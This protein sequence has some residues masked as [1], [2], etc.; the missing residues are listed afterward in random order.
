MAAAYRTTASGRAHS[1]GRYSA[2]I[3]GTTATSRIRVSWLARLK[4]TPVSHALSC[5][6]A[7]SNPLSAGVKLAPLWPCLKTTLFLRGA[8]NLGDG[9]PQ[10]D[11][12]DPVRSDAHLALG[13]VQPNEVGHSP[14]NGRDY[15]R[16]PYAHH[17]VDGEVTPE[18]DEHPERLVFELSE[19]FLTVEG[20]EHI[21]GYQ[22]TLLDRGLGGRR[23]YSAIFPVHILH[24]GA[25]PYSPDVVVALHPKG[26]VYLYAGPLVVG[27]PEVVYHLVRAVAR[28]PDHVLRIYLLAAFQLDA[29][30]R[31]L[32]GHGASNHLDAFVEEPGA[33]GSPQGRVE[34]GQDVGQGLQK[35]DPDAIRIDI[36]VV[37]GQ[38][39]VDEGVDLGRHLDPC[40]TATD[41]HEGEFGIR[42]LVADEGDLLEALYDAVADPLCVVDAPHG[43][44]VLLDTGDAEKI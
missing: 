25:V 43:H 13:A 9:G 6:P 42:H 3:T 41:D 27:Q 20:L 7:A 39:F 23:Y 37:G 44:A 1:K 21:T 17:L 12:H 11:P 28:G 18:L 5:C 4:Q 14:E 31:D 35:V 8:P 16:E 22:V 40:R 30:V 36:R 33:G 32:L 29:V 26:K 19:I 15:A 24:G 2:P 10:E 34:L 38:V